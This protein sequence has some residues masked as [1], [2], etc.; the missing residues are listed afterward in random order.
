MAPFSPNV[1]QGLRLPHNSGG[2]SQILTGPWQTQPDCQIPA[3][4]YG[5][6]P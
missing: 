5:A 4:N 6:W 2:V 1:K 3:E